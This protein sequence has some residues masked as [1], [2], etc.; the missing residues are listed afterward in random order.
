V[1]SFAEKA[2]AQQIRNDPWTQKFGRGAAALARFGDGMD[3]GQMASDSEFATSPLLRALL[4]VAPAFSS[5]GQADERTIVASALRQIAAD[6]FHTLRPILVNGVI[7]DAELAR[8][9][10]ERCEASMRVD[11]LAEQVASGRSH[12]RAPRR[13]R[14]RTADLLYRS[15]T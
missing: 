3:F 12:I 14:K 6:Q 10:I 15:L 2:L 8:Q 1:G 7:P 4:Y 11:Y 9:Y 5:A 13:T